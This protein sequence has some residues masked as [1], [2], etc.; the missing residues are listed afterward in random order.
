MLAVVVS[1][2]GT[3]ES[4]RDAGSPVAT[5]AYPESAARALGLAAERAEW[6]RRP[7][8]TVPALDGIDSAAARRLVERAL[9]S[10]DDVWLDARRDA[11]AADRLRRAARPR[12]GR[13]RTPTRRSRPREPSA[14]RSCSRRPPPARTRPRAAASRSNLETEDEIRAAA[15]RIGG[16]LLVQP[17]LTRRH[18][19][20]RRRRA[21]PGLR[22]ARR[23]R[24]RR[25]PRRAD[26][27]RRASG[28]RR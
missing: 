19:A 13:P 15:E 23:L 1:A 11:G 18:R 25:R 12:A 3:P 17:M 7:T 22:P 9:A 16:P 20:A 6:L 4:L 5:F 10:T 14:A 24:A 8:G 21:G 27:R 26:R 2:D 28:S